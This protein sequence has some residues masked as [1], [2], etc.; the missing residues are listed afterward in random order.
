MHKLMVL[1]VSGRELDDER[2]LSRL[3]QVLT[4]PAFDRRLI[5]VHGGGKEISAA[6]EHYGQPVRFVNGQRVTPPE[7]ME[8][9]QMVV[10]GSINK[11]V[12][13]RLVAAGKRAIGLGGMDLGLLRCTPYRP[14]GVDLG[15]VGIITHVEVTLLRQMLSMGWLPVLAPVALGEDDQLPYNINADR[16]AQGVAVALADPTDGDQVELLFVSDVPGVL[17]EGQVIPQLTAHDI[18]QAIE[19]GMITDGMIPKVR[20]ALDALQAGVSRVRIT[21]LDGLAQGGTLVI[22]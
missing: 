16:L 2:F 22:C 21:N 12:V 8:I 18:D 19:S 14:G 11:R 4:D 3:C 1:K 17:R 9:M 20:A 6:M 7:S 5:L 13:T 15:R 10:C